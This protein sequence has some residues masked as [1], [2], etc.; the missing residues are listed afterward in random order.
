MLKNFFK[1]GAI[2]TIP[3][4]VNRGMGLFLLPLYLN[5]CTPKEYGTFDL[6][7]LIVAIV[8]IV[9][10]VEVSQGLARYL[11][12]TSDISKKILYTSSAF[13][14]SITSLS[15]FILGI[16]FFAHLGL[17]FPGLTAGSALYLT[18]F[19]MYS[20]A[21]CYFLQNVAKWERKPFV[22]M[23]S[24]ILMFMTSAGVTLTFFVRD[25]PAI[26]SMLIGLVFGNLIGLLVVFFPLKHMIKLKV[27]KGHL[28]ELIKYSY[29]L[30]ISGG[31]VWLLLSLD[32]FWLGAEV[33]LEEVGT[34]AA[35][36]KLSSVITLPLIG[37]QT[38]LTPIIY[39]K[40]EEENI[41]DD[42]A[43]L[44]NIYVLAGILTC[45]FVQTF[46]SDIA[47]LLLNANFDDAAKLTAIL[48][49]AHFLLS[50]QVFSF[51]IGIRKKTHFL[52]IICVI[53]ILVKVT[54]NAALIPMFA[55]F[56]AALSTV[57]IALLS[58]GIRI[59]VS[60]KLYFVH[61]NFKKFSMLL[62]IS[63]MFAAYGIAYNFADYSIWLRTLSFLI[64]TFF[65]LAIYRKE[66]VKLWFDL[67]AER[68]ND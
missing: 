52:A 49:I 43:N 29:P 42:A 65:T 27:C 63:I 7:L 53:L 30:T 35:A 20:H 26:H 3:T 54:I 62:I 21:I 55:D 37:F 41:K 2:Y 44:F 61:Y 36:L 16:I 17:N 14:A 6:I 57:V 38:A 25:Y 58:F 50:V 68:E 4:F 31:T 48:V 40:F 13:W 45:L 22:Y 28:I 15:V 51:G 11:S 32:R 60:Q 18:I 46:M 8:H 10:T 67:K 33:G 47:R 5:Y 9:C 23:S 59:S 34:F 39:S 56:G 1:D 12:V 66:M 19:Y 24:N 64:V